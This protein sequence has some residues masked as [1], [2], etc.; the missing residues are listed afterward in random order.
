[1]FGAVAGGHFDSI[2]DAAAAM[3]PPP[4]R[5]YEPGPEDV[6]VY[7]RLYGAYLRL[8]DHFGRGDGLMRELNELRRH[9]KA[10][11]VLSSRGR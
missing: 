6:Q 2:A 8:H 11:P 1:M 7:E 4:S 5:R 10:E 9:A 3:A